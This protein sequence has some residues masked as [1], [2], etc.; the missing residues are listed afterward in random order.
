MDNTD[1]RILN[2]L[3]GNARMSFQEIGNAVGM[4][5]VAAK[6]RVKKLENQGVIRGYNTC[7]YR[8]DEIT[9]FIDGKPVAMATDATL[10]ISEDNYYPSDNFGNNF[11][12][13]WNFDISCPHLGQPIKRNMGEDLD[14]IAVS[15]VQKPGKMPRKMKKAFK[16]GHQLN[17]KY[18]C[19]VRNYLKHLTVDL[20]MM[21]IKGHLGSELGNKVTDIL[22]F[23]SI[24]S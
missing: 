2:L 14:E 3:K 23:E 22:Y 13:E 19:K 1:L 21:K 9:L 17:T 5:R 11:S 6:K 16:K 24:K 8:E 12:T 10:T 7:I 20:G 15:I 18:G 4:S